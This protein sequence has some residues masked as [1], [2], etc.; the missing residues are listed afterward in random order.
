MVASQ[1]ANGQFSY[2]QSF[3]NQ[4]LHTLVQELQL[5][6]AKTYGWAAVPLKQG[7][8]GFDNLAICIGLLLQKIEQDRSL[9]DNLE[10]ASDLIHQGWIINY[11]YWR[12]SKPGLKSKDYKA[13]AKPLGDERRNMCA[14]TS[15]QLLPEDEKNKD[16]VI[17]K[18]LLDKAR[19]YYTILEKQ[20]QKQVQKQ[21]LKEEKMVPVEEVE[22]ETQVE[23]T[24]EVDVEDNADVKVPN[25]DHLVFTQPMLEHIARFILELKEK[26]YLPIEKLHELASE[27][28]KKDFTYVKCAKVQYE[29]PVA[30]AETRDSSPARKISSSKNTDE[31]CTYKFTSRHK[32]RAGQVC[33]ARCILGTNLCREHTKPPTSTLKQTKLA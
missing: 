30:V 29:E 21:L 16:R 32:T 24:M 3:L 22:E 20:V 31:G 13:P 23:E 2:N 19:D 17:A 10:L 25:F 11:V 15:F 5:Y 28:F 8:F 27:H 12:D 6:Q 33:G 1:T 7:G 14:I 26:K 4:P 9:L 18:F